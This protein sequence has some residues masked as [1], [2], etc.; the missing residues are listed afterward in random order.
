MRIRDKEIKL[1]IVTGDLTQ[2]AKKREFL[3]A[4]EFISSLNSPLFVVPGNHD[5]PLYNLFL[6]FF[7][8]YK[9]FLRYLGPFAQNFFEN[10]DVAVFGLWTT[11]NFTIQSGK[12]HE[13]DLHELKEKFS[14]VPAHKIKIIACHHPLKSDKNLKEALGTNPDFILW[15]HTHQ[16]GVTKLGAT[17][18]LSSGTSTSTRTK[19]EANSFNYMTFNNDEVVIEIYRHSKLLTA[20][21]VIDRQTFKLS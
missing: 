5:V 4:R 12:L 13:K 2:R 16:S 3:A 8:P 10:E 7:S 19:T 11:D 18:L 15:G 20:F 6:R 1:A 9:K 17:L 21:E 14:A